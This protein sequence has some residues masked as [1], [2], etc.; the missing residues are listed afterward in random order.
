MSFILKERDQS[1]D[2]RNGELNLAHGKV[3]T[4]CFMP[5]GTNA[6]V[7]AASVEDLE[8]LGIRLILSNAYHLYLRPGIDVIE[9]AGGLHRFMAWNHNI[10]TDSGGFQ[11]FS[12]APFRKIQGEGVYFRSHLD[13]SD[14]LLTPERIVEIQHSLKSDV[15]MPLDVCTPFGISM[16]EAR[17]AVRRTTEWAE[18]SL[19]AWR[20]RMELDESSIGLL[21]AIVQGNFYEELRRESAEQLCS[22]DL[23][24]FAIGGL[25]VGESFEQFRDLLSYTAA[26]IPSEK[27]RYLMGVGTPEYIFEAVE[28]GIDLFD[29]V[30]PTR[31]ARNALAF[32][33]RGNLNLRLEKNKYDQRP[34]DPECR[35]H[36]CQSFTRS[37][38]RHLFKAKEIMAPVLTTHHNLVFIQSLISDI[39]EAISE[40][41]FL[42][43]KRDFLGR[44]QEGSAEEG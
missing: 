3:Q 43:F 21:F 37:Y 29:C 30:Y 25:S 7:K 33:L 22:M 42:S 1:T 20:E 9:K 28:N 41:R 23:P 8:K 36:T 4:P 38:L 24:G 31:I 19:A 2:A 32:T 26:L 6:A 11:V 17:E 18:R 13:G 10:L 27:P 35:C 12:L 44:F 40:D 15:I 39:R 5:V 34:I 14:H 16:D